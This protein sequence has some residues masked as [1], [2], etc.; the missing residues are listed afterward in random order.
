M[1]VTLKT[2]IVHH[3]S[4][5]KQQHD[6]EWFEERRAEERGRGKGGQGKEKKRKG[7]IL[8]IVTFP[9]EA[10]LNFVDNTLCDRKTK[11]LLNIKAIKVSLKVF[12]FTAEPERKL[13]RTV[14]EPTWGSRHW[15]PLTAFSC[16]KNDVVMLITRENTQFRA[17]VYTSHF[18]RKG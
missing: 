14:W 3:S 13:S 18:I 8:M 16:L 15:W 9:S 7:C 10:M 12:I 1:T 2:V 6:L 11:S 5:V 4:K 17:E